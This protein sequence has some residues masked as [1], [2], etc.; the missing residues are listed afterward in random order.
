[1]KISILGAESLGVRGLCCSI[2]LKDRKVLID[3]GIALGWNRYGLL[4][5]PFQV[6]VGAHTRGTIIANLKDAT[7]VIFS[8]FDGDHVPL[9]NANPYQLSLASVKEW[10]ANIQIW[11]KAAE[12]SSETERIRR[13]A[14]ERIAKKKIPN[15]EN[16][17]AGP[18]NFSSPV[19][20][21]LRSK[22][23][24]SVMMTRIEE[25]GEIFVH[26]SDIQLL[27]DDAVN[28]ILSWKPD[29]VIISGPPLY[30]LTLSEQ[31][32]RTA[33]Q[34]AVR[35]A[36]NVGILIVD[37]HLMRTEEGMNWLREIAS[38]TGNRIIC[39]AE[40]MQR[41]PLLLE[42]WRKDLYQWLPVPKNWHEDYQQGR[43]DLNRYLQ[44]GWEI[45]IEKGRI[46]S[47]GFHVAN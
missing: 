35:L 25:N 38:V 46:R 7:D 26:A 20:H 40:Y 47:P 19:P 21:G 43:A 15:A 2:E 8:H 30:L 24:G 37:H 28:I 10:L 16:Q 1:M 11:S 45:L 22:K 41:E 27:N 34:N 33:K 14:I 6:A 18:F 23:T 3:P 29:I 42:A 5:H 13:E 36:Q 9:A 39:A 17:M 31:Q 4:P 32:I 12:L 44:R